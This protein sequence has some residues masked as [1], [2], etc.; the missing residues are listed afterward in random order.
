MKV[1]QIIE[2]SKLFDKLKS[3]PMKPQQREQKPMIEF[4]YF[5]GELGCCHFPPAL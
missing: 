4:G 1:E 2:N 3:T 5:A